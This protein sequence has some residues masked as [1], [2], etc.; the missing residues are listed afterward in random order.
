MCVCVFTCVIVS[1][2]VYVVCVVL[3]VCVCVFVCVCVWC[4]RKRERERER[5]CV[6]VCDFAIQYSKL[7]LEGLLSLYST[8]KS[9]LYYVAFELHVC[10][11][12]LV[13]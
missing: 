3:Y 8:P 9:V 4:E 11:H 2:F 13:M 12:S 5:V 10:P 7:V 6:C 1:G